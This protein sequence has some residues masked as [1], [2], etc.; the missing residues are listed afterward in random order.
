MH[1]LET[2]IT[3]LQMRTEKQSR[4][5]SG[6]QDRVTRIESGVTR[7]TQDYSVHINEKRSRAKRHFPSDYV[8]PSSHSVTRTSFS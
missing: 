3:Q 1:N 7:Q 5:Q 8:A 2:Q 4:E 6:G